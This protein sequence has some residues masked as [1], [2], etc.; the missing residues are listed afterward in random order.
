MVQASLLKPTRKTDA[1]YLRDQVLQAEQHETNAAGSAATATSK[2][3]EASEDQALAEAAKNQTVALKDATENLKNQAQAITVSGDVSYTPAPNQVPLAGA[4]GSIVPQWIKG[5]L[6]PVNWVEAGTATSGILIPDDTETAF[7][8]NMAR[9]FKPYFIPSV[10]TEE[11]VIY[12]DAPLAI[13]ITTDKKIRVNH[14]GV[15]ESEPLNVNND[16]VT[17][18]FGKADNQSD[19]VTIYF[20]A[21]GVQLGSTIVGDFS[22][23]AV[24]AI[25]NDGAIAGFYGCASPAHGYQNSAGTERINNP[26]DPVGYDY[27]LSPNEVDATQGTSTARPLI[28]RQPSNGDVRNG[29]DY[30]DVLSKQITDGNGYAFATIQGLEIVSE[31]FDS[32]TGE[33]ITTL[34]ITNDTS[35]YIDSGNYAVASNNKRSVSLDVIPGEFTV[36]FGWTEYAPRMTQAYVRLSEGAVTLI[37]H[38]LNPDSSSFLE[39][40]GNGRY[41]I[42]VYA[43]AT[44]SGSAAD[45]S[46]RLR[47]YDPVIGGTIKITAHQFE[48]ADTVTDYQRRVNG[49]DVVDTVTGSAWCHIYDVD[50]VLPRTLPAITDGTII[51]GGKNGIWIDTL[52]F[53]GGTFSFSDD[54]YTGAPAGLYDLIG[55]LVAWFVAD[56]TLTEPQETAVVNWLKQKGCPGEINASAELLPNPGDPF[57]ATTGWGSV[58]SATLSVESGVLKIQNPGSSIGGAR[59][60]LTVEVGEFYLFEATAHS[61]GNSNGRYL[62]LGSTVSGSEYYNGGN[63]S[64]YSRIVQATTTDLSILFQPNNNV[65][66]AYNTVGGVSVKKL[67]LN[68][69]A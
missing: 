42:G 35:C 6:K 64:N 67:T 47:V 21:N 29:V 41:R 20:I 63:S 19:T 5:A 68:T 36:D 17:F 12:D 49:Y 38:A 25:F 37:T 8:A 48:F 28:G 43:Q 58:N 10:M 61:L 22:D 50:D 62:K 24:R 34:K 4:D 9:F 56:A 2:A 66:D 60:V 55:D 18:G 45:Q 39:D 46:H 27:D 69:G 7:T 32:S 31:V 15:Y 26:G 33:M 30:S 54:G 65:S 13:C 16:W 51:I 23:L 14:Y 59:E 11:L 3:T 40:K 44:D 1:K 53:G 57:T 52:T